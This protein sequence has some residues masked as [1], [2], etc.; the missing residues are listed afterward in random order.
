MSF[1]PIRLFPRQSS[2]SRS[3]ERDNSRRL[4]DGAHLEQIF[5]MLKLQV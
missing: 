2:L 3:V 4:I 1:H 5:V